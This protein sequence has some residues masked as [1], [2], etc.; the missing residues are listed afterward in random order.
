M[1]YV[2]FPS[3]GER[4]QFHPQISL[5]KL[6]FKLH[7]YPPVADR[8]RTLLSSQAPPSMPIA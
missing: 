7:H 4:C 6:N 3:K 1:H 8:G 2:F 5:R